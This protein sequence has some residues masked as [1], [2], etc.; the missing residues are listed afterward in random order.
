MPGAVP[1][2]STF[3]LSNATMPYALQIANKGA[4]T[5]MRENPAL[6]KG[7]NVYGGKITNKGVA[8]S[9]GLAYEPISF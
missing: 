3:A 8:D 5:A 9:Q 2:T 7:L 4:E 1:R 6:L